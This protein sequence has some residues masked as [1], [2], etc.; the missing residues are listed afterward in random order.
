MEITK[1]F[2]VGENEVL[3]LVE[4]CYLYVESDRDIIDFSYKENFFSYLYR[5]FLLIR[6]FRERL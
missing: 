1:V 4:V 5:V 2:E 3:K 6:I